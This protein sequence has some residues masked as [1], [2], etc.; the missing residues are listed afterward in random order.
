M[1]TIYVQKENVKA[2]CRNRIQTLSCTK[3]TMF[4][5]PSVPVQNPPSCYWLAFAPS[6]VTIH[7]PNRKLEHKRS[8]A[9]RNRFVQC[10]SNGRFNMVD[11]LLAFDDIA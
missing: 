6:L 4:S 9:I 1:S 5:P 10:K 11:V 2:L 7:T 8:S 3:L